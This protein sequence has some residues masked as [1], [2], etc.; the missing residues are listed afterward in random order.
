L[1]VASD[2]ASALILEI[3]DE[4]NKKPKKVISN[5]TTDDGHFEVPSDN[6]GDS[7]RIVHLQ[8]RK[9]S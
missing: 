8:E 9:R 6:K 2:R 3:A 5:V 7:R 4:E 1:I